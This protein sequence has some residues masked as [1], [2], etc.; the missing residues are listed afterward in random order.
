MRTPSALVCS[1]DGVIV[2][3]R[4]WH[5]R[6]RL[7]AL[8][9]RLCLCLEVDGFPR[10]ALALRSLAACCRPGVPL[11]LGAFSS[12]CAPIGVSF[13]WARGSEPIMADDDFD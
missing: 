6:T 10:H 7:L 9:P 13:S 8:V 12:L 11:P 2:S 1:F 4:R 5:P 3:V